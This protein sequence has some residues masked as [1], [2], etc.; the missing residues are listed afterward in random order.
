VGAL[1]LAVA[2]LGLALA[3]VAVVG[4]D[5][6]SCRATAWNAVPAAADLPAGWTLG[7]SQFGADGLAASLVGP[8]SADDPTSAPT[9][10]V[11][12]S[13]FDGDAGTALDRTR[14]A[15]DAAGMVTIDRSDLGDAGFTIQDASAVT[16]AVYFRR[17]GLV[18]HLTPSGTVDARP[19][20]PRP[21]ARRGRRPG[22]LGGRRSRPASS[23][24]PSTPPTSEEPAI[25][26]G[27]KLHPRGQPQPR[28][29]LRGHEA[30]RRPAGRGRRNNAHQ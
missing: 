7:T 3:A 24:S 8:A 27:G 5:R 12:V 14:D 21:G 28:V 1:A 30:P 11:L 22:R 20:T 9:V 15:A 10:Y 4:P 26:R 19:S 23:T 29:E 17:G 18:A 16:E 6:G 2:A 13:C 25:R